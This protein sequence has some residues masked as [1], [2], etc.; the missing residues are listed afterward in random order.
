MRPPED[1]IADGRRLGADRLQQQAQWPRQ[2]RDAA[3]RIVRLDDV[4]KGVAQR[5]GDDDGQDEPEDDER[6][7]S[8]REARWADD[9]APPGTVEN[10]E[11]DEPHEEVGEGD[12]EIPQDAAQRPGQDRAHEAVRQVVA[13]RDEQDEEAPEDERVCQSGT[14][15]V[16]QPLLPE[17]EDAEPGDAVQHPSAAIE[18]APGT[19]DGHVQRGA[20]PEEVGG[21]RDRQ[22]DERVVRDRRRHGAAMVRPRGGATRRSRAGRPTARGA[23]GRLL[24]AARPRGAGPAGSPGATRRRPSAIRGD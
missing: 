15:V 23:S 1:A 7:A 18:R 24:R 10:P 9:G 16:E 19:Q 2:Q 21:Q 17:D 6:V 4:A 22:H 11:D 14:D 3:R 13:G 8:Q 20:A 5:L 12:G